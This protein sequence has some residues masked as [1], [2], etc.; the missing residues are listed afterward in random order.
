MTRTG[1]VEFQMIYKL[2][3]ESVIR[4]YHV[5]K[6]TW[7]PKAD[8]ELECQ[9]DTRKEAKD[10]DGRAV[11]LFKSPNRGENKT[12]VGH[13][14]I[15]ISILIHYFLKADES[16]KVSAQVTGKRRREVGLVVPARFTACTATQRQ[17]QIFDSELNKYKARFVHLELIYEPGL[18]SSPT[19]VKHR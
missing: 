16:D 14:P 8:D 19:S 7:T 18:R 13:V 17:A 5:Y 10:Y 9:E 3:F 11:G 4:G 12:L 1:V 2:S 15:E 6:A